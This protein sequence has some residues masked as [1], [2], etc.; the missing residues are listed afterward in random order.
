MI[1]FVL[2]SFSLMGSWIEVTEGSI[3]DFV[4]APVGDDGN[5]EQD[6]GGW[7]TEK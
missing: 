7:T 2:R 4:V 3:K 6:I 5:L 1:R